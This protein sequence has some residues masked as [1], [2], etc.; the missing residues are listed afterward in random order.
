M[1]PANIFL[2]Y[3]RDDSESETRLIEKVLKDSGHNVFMDRTEIELGERWPDKIKKSLENSNLVIV[4]IGNKWLTTDYA[5]GR[6]RID[7]EDDWVRI[8]LRMA[9]QKNKTIIPVLVNRAAMPDSRSLPDDLKDLPNWQA[10]TCTRENWENDT[11]IL[12]QRIVVF[13]EGSFSKSR[14][15]FLLTSES[16][17]RK[18]LLKQIGW[19][20]GVD[21]LST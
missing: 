9:L 13:M 14:P 6:R 10:L 11:K 12:L 7:G 1:T 17:R 20:E 2:S 4:V 19:E 21:Y 5:D 8:E 3:R 15:T 16:P 18:E